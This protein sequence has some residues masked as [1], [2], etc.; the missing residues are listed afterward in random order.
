ME[1]RHVW[2]CIGYM[3]R[4][5]YVSMV[6]NEHVFVMA[7]EYIMTVAIAVSDSVLRC[8]MLE[9]TRMLNHL[10]NIGCHAGDLGC[11]MCVL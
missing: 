3:D 2:Q 1:L 11:L 6:C 5:D 4:L 7:V 8:I 10:L 9:C